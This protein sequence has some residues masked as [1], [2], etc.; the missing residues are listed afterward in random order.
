M[1]FSLIQASKAFPCP[2]CGVYAKEECWPRAETDTNWVHQ[3]RVKTAQFNNQGLSRPF[4]V[5]SI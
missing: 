4:T 1:A 3:V 2:A 5:V